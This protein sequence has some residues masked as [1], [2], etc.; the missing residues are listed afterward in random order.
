MSYSAITA[1]AVAYILGIVALIYLFLPKYFILIR[2]YKTKLTKNLLS[3]ELSPD[4]YVINAYYDKRILAVRVFVNSENSFANMSC[5]LEFKNYFADCS[6]RFVS[7]KI[8]DKPHSHIIVK[9]NHRNYPKKL[10]LNKKQ[11]PISYSY[12]GKPKYK[13]SVCFC[14]MVNYSATN[15][16]I[17]TIESY[18]YFGVDHFTI[19][20]TSVSSEVEKVLKYYEAMNLTEVIT[21]NSTIE[22]NPLIKYQGFGQVFK[23]DDCL[24]RNMR[25]SKN[26]IFSDLDE[27]I[28][29]NEGSNIL[30]TLYKYDKINNHYYT[31]RSFFY[32]QEVYDKED[33]LITDL[34]DS[35]IF[36]YREYCIIRPGYVVKNVYTKPT[37]LYEVDIHVVGDGSSKLRGC[38]VPIEIGHVRHTRRIKSIN[39]P[40]CQSNWTLQPPDVRE[41]AIIKNVEIVK[42]L[43]NVS[44]VDNTNQTRF[45]DL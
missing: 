1:I 5:M 42:N 18:R 14:K 37:M 17:Q 22:F 13:L 6:Y 32:H 28:W 2:T 10:Y 11:I 30:K 39:Y 34:R 38:I 24:Y 26:I 12:N 9:V 4:V 31:F 23:N 25:I 20:K 33:R 15:R 45:L 41:N 7:Y 21:W 36:K 8:N 27:I 43:L 16:L 44:F 35:D 3:I 19:Y 29:P 40:Q